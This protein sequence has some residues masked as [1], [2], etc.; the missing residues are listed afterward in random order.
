MQKIYSR[1][2]IRMCVCLR[3]VR[4]CGPRL[5]WSCKNRPQIKMAGQGGLTDSMYLEFPFP[6]SGSANDSLRLTLIVLFCTIHQ[7][8][9]RFFQHDPILTKQII[10]YSQDV[11]KL[12]DIARLTR[13]RLKMNTRQR[14]QTNPFSQ[15]SC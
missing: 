1:L 12:S 2:R 14:I 9:K 7:Y 3:G 5:L 13:H 11:A 8:L 15:N 4:Q 6:A 10:T